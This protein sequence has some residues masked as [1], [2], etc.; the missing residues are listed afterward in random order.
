MTTILSWKKLRSTFRPAVALLV[1]WL[2]ITAVS[3][4][5]GPA[6]IYKYVVWAALIP[7]FIWIFTILQRTEIDQGDKEKMPFFC[8]FAAAILTLAYSFIAMVINVNFMFLIG[9][10]H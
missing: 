7:C 4:Q 6:P 5:T 10:Q 9:G 8:F 3:V 1:F 2:L